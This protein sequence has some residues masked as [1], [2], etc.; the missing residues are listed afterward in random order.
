MSLVEQGRVVRV[1]EASPPRQSPPPPPP[2]LGRY[3]F[4]D[5]RVTPAGPG[6]PVD[7]TAYLLFYA[8]LDP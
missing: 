6:P 8:R 2:P 5:T 3:C 1:G 7:G 4:N